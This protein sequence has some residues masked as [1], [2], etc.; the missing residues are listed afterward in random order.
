MREIEKVGG[1]PAWISPALDYCLDVEKTDDPRRVI[2]VCLSGRGG[3]L[4]GEFQRHLQQTSS[5]PP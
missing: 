1:N 3:L 2:A 5:M 4:S